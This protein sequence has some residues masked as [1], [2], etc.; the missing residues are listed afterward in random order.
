MSVWFAL[1]LVQAWSSISIIFESGRE[2]VWE[3]IR[4]EF[5]VGAISSLFVMT[6]SIRAGYGRAWPRGCRLHHVCVP[7]VG[8]RGRCI[9]RKMDFIAL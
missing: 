7:G 4:G 2:A 5:D 3:G 9:C 8:R 6:R 1:L